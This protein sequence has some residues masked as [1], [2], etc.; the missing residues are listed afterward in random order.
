MQEIVNGQ[1]AAFAAS[2]FYF[3]EGD[4]KMN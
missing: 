2:G 1:E 4:W 3:R